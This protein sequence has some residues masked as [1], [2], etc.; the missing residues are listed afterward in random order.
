MRGEY[1]AVTAWF[2]VA[3]MIGGIGQSVATCFPIAYD[4]SEARG[5]RD[6][7]GMMPVTGAT[8]LTAVSSWLRS[9]PGNAG[10]TVAY[11]IAFAAPSFTFSLQARNLHWRDTVRVS[12]PV[13]SLAFPR[14]AMAAARADAA[15]IVLAFN[16]FLRLGLLSLPT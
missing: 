6:V 13:L 4:P 8:A 9:S 16:M 10:Q 15:L 12:Q 5:Y 7:A 3:L 14:R 2:G 1:S 11:P